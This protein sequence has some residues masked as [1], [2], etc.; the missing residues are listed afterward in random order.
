[1]YLKTTFSKNSTDYFQER[2]AEREIMQSEDMNGSHLILFDES[3]SVYQYFDINMP[4]LVIYE[5]LNIGAD[6]MV[7]QEFSENNRI[8]KERQYTEFTQQSRKLHSHNFYE[9]TFVLSGQLTMRIEDENIIYNQGDCCICNRN[10][11]HMELME[12]DTEIVLF[13]IKEERS[14]ERRVGKECV[15]TCRSRWSPYH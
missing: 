15:S 8:L 2:P 9:L 12:Q 3:S 10:I 11:H 4:Y 13:L 7:Y 6:L 1:M 5:S 14:E